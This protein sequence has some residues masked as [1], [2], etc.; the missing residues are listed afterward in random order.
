MIFL[1]DV[2]HTV[3]P[4]NRSKSK[5]KSCYNRCLQLVLEH[6]I[7]SVVIFLCTYD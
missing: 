3:G 6:K 4:M 1:S 5:L 7:R 2:L